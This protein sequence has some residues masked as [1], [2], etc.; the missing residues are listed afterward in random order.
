MPDYDFSNLSSRSFE[1]LIQ[2]LS[3]KIIGPGLVL[4]GDGPDGG[5]EATF[6]GLVPYPSLNNAWDGYGVMQAKFRQRCTNNS[7]DGKWALSQLK[8]EINKYLDP[9]HHLRQ[10]EY[11]IFVTNVVLTPVNVRGYK[12]QARHLLEDFVSRSALK[13]YDIWDYDKLRAFLDGQKDIR[14]AYTAWITPG[15]VLAQIAERLNW[16]TANLKNTLHNFLQK[17]LLSDQYVNLEQ[18]GHDT[19]ERVALAQVF[20]DLNTTDDREYSHT[21]SAMDGE[22]RIHEP[23]ASV[24]SHVASRGF[25][26]RILAIS[27]E[28][29]DPK[30][31]A[32]ESIVPGRKPQTARH[33]RG[34]FVLIGGPGQGK[35]TVAQFLCQILRAA[36]ISRLPNEALSPELQSA[37]SLLKLHCHADDI[38]DSPVPRFPFRV[39][40]SE[41]A[42]ALS[43]TRLPQVNSIISYLAHVIS[44]R[45]DRT[46]SVDDLRV[47]IAKYPCLIVFDGLDEVPSSSNRDQVLDAIRAFWVDA[48]ESNADLLCLATS[49]PQGY[50]E[51]FAPS[52]YQHERLAPLTKTVGLHFANRLVD[53]RYGS[54]TDRKEKILRRLERSFNNESTARL[55]RSPLQVTIMTALVD[56]LG[57]PPQAR[58]SLFKAYYD[59]I[60]QRELERDIPA[61]TI[62]REFRPDINSIHNRVGLI[63]QLDSEQ[64]GG[65]DTKFSK[66]RF[67]RLVTRRLEDEGHDSQ[68][69]AHLRGQIVKAA[70]E[71]LV[72]LVG[73]ESDQVGFEIRSLQEFMASESLMEGKDIE[74]QERL[75]EIAP[76]P[77]WRNV[78]LFAAGKCFSD[79]QHL[80]ETIYTITAMLNERSS[81][82][83]AAACLA[84]SGLAIDLLEDGLCRRQP[85]Y[86][87]AFTRIAI[88]A[89]DIPYSRFHQLLATSYE[90]RLK[91]V[92]TEEI[93]RRLADQ[94][95]HIRLSAWNC[96]LRLPITDDPW[97][98]QLAQE[99]WP[100]EPDE[101]FQILEVC[102]GF[103]RNTWAAGRYLNLIPLLPVERL[104]DLYHLG[105]AGVSDASNLL[106]IAAEA[107]KHVSP[108]TPRHLP[109]TNVLSGMN[110]FP[111]IQ[112]S[113]LG[114][115]SFDLASTQ[116]SS[117]APSWF[118]ELRNLRD[119]HPTWWVYSSAAR[120]LQDPSKETLGREL[121]SLAPLLNCLDNRNDTYGYWQ[122]PWPI[123]ACL[124]VCTSAKDMLDLSNQALAG[125]LGDTEDWIAAEQRWISS[126]V[127]EHDINSMTD[128]RL[129]FDTA[130]KS[131]G[132]PTTLHIWPA[133]GPDSDVI[134]FLEHM[135]HIH[136]NMAASRSR[137]FV[138]D[139][140]VKCLLGM[141]L[142]RHPEVT[143]QSFR[144]SPNKLKSVFLDLSYA[145]SL[146]IQIASLIAECIEESA[147]D[148]HIVDLFSVMKERDIRFTSYRLPRG[149][150][151]TGVDRL[152]SV[153]LRLSGSDRAKVLLP[154]LGF[155][156]E[157]GELPSKIRNLPSPDNYQESS[158]KTAALIIKLASEPWQVDNAELVI[159]HVLKTV[160]GCSS[161]ET[162]ERLIN[163]FER[164]RPVSRWFEKFLVSFEKTL[165]RDNYALNV[166]SLR[167]LQL[168]LRRRTSRFA[169]P[170]SSAKFKIPKGIIREV[171]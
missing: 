84:G 69:I 20:I 142:F 148:C 50:N 77:N 48:T 119:H 38:T 129:P 2:A 59:V 159:N 80:R 160:D 158:E 24:S 55:M 52:Y 10:P 105:S 120:F 167:L 163:T 60:Y 102:Q 45:T 100:D 41:F 14:H 154:I 98:T 57:Q 97:P 106:S 118:L 138:A 83:T 150:N 162:F 79:R 35:T 93:Q 3:A 37:L 166:R 67:V 168:A 113:P 157:H 110:H 141:S 70:L 61:S 112:V 54:D 53:I 169:D 161:I 65:T 147:S 90:P 137:R 23:Y 13:G 31:L 43:S 155:L 40:L 152:W 144:V 64:A 36:I 76:L 107:T 15:D 21:L 73:L 145:Y 101:Q 124:N 122:L 104:R 134:E 1:Q 99:Y 42:S 123:T 92:Y 156:A 72:F 5:R 115:R 135:L 56:R 139:L 49:R 34:R 30:S 11:F 86:V 88:R 96:L 111:R 17:Q 85:K 32:N 58:W 18:A 164:R 8:S 136:A 128:V 165:P 151:Q 19:S 75:A 126:G 71:R 51:D 66:Q 44:K 140:I 143:E 114:H 153:F 27:S 68:G 26:K 87:D 81:D 125:E 121:E 89:L 103:F 108:A 39:I 171:R 25:I 62:L 22:D 146:P 7:D 149:V 130:L 94:R 132:F 170:S 9:T 116:Q 47:W 82:E 131:I 117:D 63:L 4:F 16:D 46:V 33:S 127:S 28:R 133:M 12:D 29:L 91:Q 95:A 6:E 78:F 74:V 109:Q